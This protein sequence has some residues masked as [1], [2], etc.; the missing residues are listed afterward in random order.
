MTPNY[1]GV[2]FSG[3]GFLRLHSSRILQAL[4]DS[5]DMRKILIFGLF[6]SLAVNASEDMCYQKGAEA[7]HIFNQVMESSEYDVKITD[8]GSKDPAEVYIT[9]PPKY[10]GIPF[11]S[12]TAITNGYNSFSA[13]LATVLK[14]GKIHSGFYLANSEF[15][16]IKIIANYESKQ[17][18]EG[19]QITKE[20]VSYN[21]PISHNKTKH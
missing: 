3:G 5:K 17:P 19:I 13:D 20:Y 21:V 4:C 10:K 18:C 9:L 2:Y 14:E 16:N 1:L 11:S 12:L 6:I 15:S 8:N 7:P